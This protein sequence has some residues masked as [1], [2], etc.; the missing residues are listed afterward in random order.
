VG[1]YAFNLPP[2]LILWKAIAGSELLAVLFSSDTPFSGLVEGEP[3]FH[4]KGSPP[5]GNFRDFLGTN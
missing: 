4:L 5:E 1:G 3:C 2:L